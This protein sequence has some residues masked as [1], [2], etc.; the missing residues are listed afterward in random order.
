MWLSD[1]QFFV[2]K[3]TVLVFFLFAK[4]NMYNVLTFKVSP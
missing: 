4:K 2:E 3:Q 1:I